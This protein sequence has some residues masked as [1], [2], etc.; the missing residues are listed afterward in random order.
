M[1]GWRWL[2]EGAAELLLELLGGLLF[3]G[4]GFGVLFLF[5]GERAFDASAELAWLL[6]GGVLVGGIVAFFVLRERLQRPRI[7]P[8]PPPP[9]PE[10]R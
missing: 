1:S 4:V 2:G 9:P 5:R 3:V 6:G 7:R 10:A 8:R